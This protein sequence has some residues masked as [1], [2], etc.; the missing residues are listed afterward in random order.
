[1]II[2]NF[3]PHPG[4]F[5][6]ILAISCDSFNEEV[7]RVIGRHRPGH[8]HLASLVNARDWCQKYHVAFKINSVVTIHNWEENMSEDILNLNP[9]RWKVRNYFYV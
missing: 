3:L 2:I 7:N 4:E 5:L 8:Q 6:D 1:M 9:V